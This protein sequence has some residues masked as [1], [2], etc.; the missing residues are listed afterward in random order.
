MS[1]LHDYWLLKRT[2]YGLKRS[3][4]LCY[5]KAVHCSTKVELSKVVN[6]PCISQGQL[7]KVYAHYLWDRILML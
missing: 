3:L 1:Q 2:I 4:K 5:D 6:A 7:S